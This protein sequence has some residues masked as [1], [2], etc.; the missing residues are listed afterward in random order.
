[1]TNQTS[2]QQ[3]TAADGVS[4]SLR[5]LGTR[6]WL[7]LGIALWAVAIIAFLSTISG[8]FVPLVVAVTMAMLFYPLVD[9]LESRRVNRSIGGLLVI[10]FMII[11]YGVSGMIADLALLL[12]FQDGEVLHSA[13]YCCLFRSAWFGMVA[14]HAT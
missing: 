11:Y 10:A 5:A 1:M 7:Y 14:V 13:V 4:P 12:V 2:I 6:S 3:T 8:V 9:G